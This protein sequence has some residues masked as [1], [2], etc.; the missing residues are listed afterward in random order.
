MD[1]NVY[2]LWEVLT[3]NGYECVHAV[4]HPYVSGT[5]TMASSETRRSRHGR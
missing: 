1:T 4:V 3:L 2:M 5:M